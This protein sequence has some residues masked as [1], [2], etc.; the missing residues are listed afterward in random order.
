VDD[1]VATNNVGLD[2]IDGVALCVSDRDLSVL[3]V[4]REFRSIDGLDLAGLDVLAEHLACNN[5][6]GEDRLELLRGQRGDCSGGK[7]GKR[8]IGRSEDGERAL[9]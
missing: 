3:H 9:A 8:L 1:T 6:V 4:D 5:V 7:L 2:D